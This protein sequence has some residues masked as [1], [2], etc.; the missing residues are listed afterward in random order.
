MASLSDPAFSSHGD[1]LD[2]LHSTVL[3]PKGLGTLLVTIVVIFLVSEAYHAD[4]PRIQGIPEVPFALPF[5][6][7]LYRLGGRAGQND[8]TIF[9]EWGKQLKSPVFQ[10]LF[11]NQR[12]VI[13]SDW[14]TIRELWLRQS[15]A[16][17][18]RPHQP[19]F[20]DK[21]GIDLTGSCM[22]DQIRKCRA[23][24]MRALAKPNWPKYYHLLEPS[25]A[26][27]IA[28]VYQ[29]SDN[30]R[31]AMD[32]YAFLRQIVFDLALSLTY[33]ARFGDVDDE[34]TLGLI[35]S[36]NTISAFRSTTRKY[37][38]FVHISRLIPEPTSQIVAA[39]KTRRWHRD[40]LYQQYQDRVAR[41]ETVDCIVTSLTQD[42]LTTEEIHG[43]CLGLLQAAPD[44]VAS[45]LYQAMAWLSSPE[46]KPTQERAL[47]AILDAYHGDRTK[48]WN[49]A[50]REERVPLISSINKETLRFYTV[51]PY[52]TPRRTTQ[53]VKL[54]NG[55]TL[56][57][58][59]TLVMNAQEA[60]HEEAHY[61]ADAWKF[62]PDRFIDSSEAVGAGLP[63]L[64]FGAGSRICP[65]V[66][67]S[68]RIICALLTRLILA[69]EMDGS[70]QEGRSPNVDP[71]DFSNVYDRLVAHPRYYDCHYKARDPAWLESVLKEAEMEA[72]S[73]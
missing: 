12:T 32:T 39:E 50:F 6:G 22:T 29:K 26:N 31:A 72:A 69:F 16:L 27:F 40:I 14:A 5:I 52:A 13:V 51:T 9:T 20:L 23:A 11:G 25:S 68:N 10:C 53:E 4:F 46:G 57:K 37:R 41:G 30:G 3:S 2:L 19:G 54:P 42:G 36:I 48:A 59:I 38:F 67:I 63:H 62:N 21:L 71:L 73:N 56:P 49:M 55:V 43:T 70:S 66:A 45:G 24:G 60:N 17:I 35:K 34:F 8:S 44:T 1:V 33:G 7:H 15:N 47:Q 61:G 18:D 65:A 64:T 58:G 28:S